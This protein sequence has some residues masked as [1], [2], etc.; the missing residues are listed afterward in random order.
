MR[1]SSVEEL[2]TLLMV[3]FHCLSDEQYIEIFSETL[4]LY[5]HSKPS[6][7]EMLMKRIDRLEKFLDEMPSNHELPLF[8]EGL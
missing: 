6:D 2:K 3:V 5:E 7:L 4:G 8:M 1:I